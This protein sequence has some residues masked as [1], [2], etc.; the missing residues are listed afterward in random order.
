[1]KNVAVV[2]LGNLGRR[3]LESLLEYEEKLCVYGVEIN[4]KVLPELYK[5]YNK[6]TIVSSIEELPD[7]IDLCIVATSSGPRRMV[8]EQLFLHSKVSYVILEKVLFQKSDDYDYVGKLLRDNK[9]KAWINCARREQREYID[10]Q[11]RLNGE[12]IHS[13]TVSGS[14][15]GMCCNSIHMIDLAQK[16]AGSDKL[17]VIECVA[18][19]EIYDSKRV[20]YKEM[21]GTISGIINEDVSFQITCTHGINPMM[22]TI[23]S[24]NHQIVIEEGKG[25]MHIA[26]KGNEWHWNT[27]EFIIEYQ[28]KLTG[29]VS[30]RILEQGDCNLP[31]YEDVMQIHKRYIEMWLK[32]FQEHGWGGD[33]CPIT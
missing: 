33:I 32:V 5:K 23:N 6:A 26:G 2:G 7:E 19:P 15:W 31:K 8:L 20:G 10:L 29:R 13:M 25:L 27:H 12:K 17:N 28:S 22:I 14:E 11:D 3:H 1:M 4:D 24:D 18:F 21:F 9:C 16:L 30:K